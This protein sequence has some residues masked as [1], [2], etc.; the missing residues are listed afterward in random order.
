LKF[1][2]RYPIFIRTLVNARS[3]GILQIS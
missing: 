3:Q 2:L 1:V